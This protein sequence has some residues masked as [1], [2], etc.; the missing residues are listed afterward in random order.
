M[1]TAE[2]DPGLG[3]FAGMGFALVHPDDHIVELH[4]EGKFVARFSQ[5]GATPESLQAEC[6]KHLVNDHGWD[7]AIFKSE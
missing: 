2:R 6:A 5:L 3:S 7:G 1:T 4:H